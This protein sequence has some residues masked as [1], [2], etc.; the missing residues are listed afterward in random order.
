LGEAASWHSGRRHRC[1][2]IQAPERL[3]MRGNVPRLRGTKIK[4]AHVL[5]YS[6][7]AKDKPNISNTLLRGQL[8]MVTSFR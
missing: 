5:F 3:I 4:A 1:G 2:I 8:T 7:G 6:P